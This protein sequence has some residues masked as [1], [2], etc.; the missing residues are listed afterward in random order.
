MIAAGRHAQIK[1]QYPKSGGIIEKCAFGVT[2]LKIKFIP[3]A[4]PETT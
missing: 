1:S 4:P 2:L 3:D